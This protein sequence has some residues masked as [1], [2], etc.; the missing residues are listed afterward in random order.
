MILKRLS[1]GNS[2][3]N[4]ATQVQNH[5]GGSAHMRTDINGK[6][7]WGSGLFRIGLNRWLSASNSGWYVNEGS[8]SPAYFKNA[9]RIDIESWDHPFGADTVELAG[10]AHYNNHPRNQTIGHWLTVSAYRN[11]GE[12]TRFSDPS[13][14]VWSA[15]SQ[16]FNASTNSFVNTY[17]Q[18]NG[19]TW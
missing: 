10:G 2:A 9:L 11:Y 4:N 1:A 3:Y 17:L 6:T 18:N 15:A 7:G 19:I 8:P 12:T 16:A 14:S 5:I 13:T